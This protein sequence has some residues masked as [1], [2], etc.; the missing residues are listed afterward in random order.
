LPLLVRVRA[1]PANAV[2]LLGDVRQLEVRRER[3][4]HACLPLERQRCNRRGQFP[5]VG[6]LARGARKA[7]DALDVVE[8]RLVLL[9]DEHAAE[10]VAEQAD[11]APERRVG[12][13]VSPHSHRSRVGLNPGKTGQSGRGT[14]IP[15]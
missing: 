10:Q 13:L 11:V 14:T 4:Q 12:G 5:L 7:A 6:A 3:A 8:Q 1:P 15:R 9:L 2:L